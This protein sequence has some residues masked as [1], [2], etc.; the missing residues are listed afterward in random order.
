[1][2]T[3]RHN[4]CGRFELDFLDVATVMVLCNT[5]CESLQWESG[6]RDEGL[7]SP[8]LR[9]GFLKVYPGS[10]VVQGTCCHSGIIFRPTY[11]SSALLFANL[12]QQILL[13][14]SQC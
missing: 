11:I 9:G 12:I 7:L 14:V 1:M 13:S 6:G 2:S 5:V 10:W 4:M 8:S 3:C